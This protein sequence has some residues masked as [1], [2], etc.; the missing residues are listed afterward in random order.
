M[1]GAA[2]LIVATVI[3]IS[4]DHT[5]L[6]H[7]ADGQTLSFKTGQ[8]EDGQTFV[9]VELDREFARALSVLDTAATVEAFANLPVT[10]L[11]N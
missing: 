6:G 10:G 2:G 11:P 3:K 7:L 1:V 4:L 5:A 9:H 8:D